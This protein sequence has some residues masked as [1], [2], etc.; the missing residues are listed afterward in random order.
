MI[1]NL[2]YELSELNL[3]VR[4]VTLADQKKNILAKSDFTK[5]SEIFKELESHGYREFFQNP[6]KS[7]QDW[8][9]FL[10]RSYRQECIAL[11]A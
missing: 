7:V 1:E 9:R 4:L 8:T 10:I 3:K 2:I 6:S 5:L 11:R